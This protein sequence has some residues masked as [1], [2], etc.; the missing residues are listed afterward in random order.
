MRFISPGDIMAR[1]F[2]RGRAA[3][4]NRAAVRRTMMARTNL[5]SAL[6][7]LQ[8]YRT[9][10]HI[11]FNQG[12][13]NDQNRLNRE[14]R[15]AFRRAGHASVLPLTRNKMINKLA[16][17]VRAKPSAPHRKVTVPTLRL[18]YG[19]RINGRGPNV[20]VLSPNGN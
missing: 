2:N 4:N 19:R 16:I 9:H 3:A 10:R 11:G 1:L 15:N 18:N 14:I 17:A 6:R 13:R 7:A 5:L 12:A 20:L 8:T